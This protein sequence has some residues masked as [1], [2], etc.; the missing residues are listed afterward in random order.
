MPPPMY[1]S[2]VTKHASGQT[3]HLIIGNCVDYDNLV[4]DFTVFDA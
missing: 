1:E 3:L 2:Q 4:C